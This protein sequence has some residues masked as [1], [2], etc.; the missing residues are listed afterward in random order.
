MSRNS[1]VVSLLSPFVDRIRAAAAV[2]GSVGLHQPP[3]TA[4]TFPLPTSEVQTTTNGQR[5]KYLNS[6]AKNNSNA[7][8]LGKGGWPQQD[9]LHYPPMQIDSFIQPAMGAEHQPSGA[10]TTFHTH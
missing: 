7:H 10:K 5:K 6:T 8:Q 1:C 3:G 2:Q 4:P 9:P